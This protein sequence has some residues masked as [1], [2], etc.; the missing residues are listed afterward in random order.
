MA[1]TPAAGPGGAYRAVIV[2]TGFSGLCMAIGLKRSGVHDFVILEKAGEVGGTWRENTY[3]GCACDIMSL[4]YSFSFEPKSDWSRMFP[5]QHELLDYIKGVVDKYDL[6]QHIRF[7][8]EVTGA[9]YDD[10]S[11]TWRVT[12]QGEGAAPGEVVRGQA[13]MAGMGPLHQPNVPDLPGLASFEGE[14]FHSAEWNHDYD[15]AGKHVAVIGTGASAIQFVPRIAREVG[16]LTLF[17]RTPPWILPKPDRPVL[18][19][20]R[21]LFK[22]VPGVQR[23]YRSAI[24]LV[25]E[26]FVLGFENPRLLKLASGLAQWH[27]K[28]QVP[29]AELRAKLTPRYT[30]GCKRTLVSSDYYPALTRDN[31]QV[32]TAGVAEVRPRS[33]VAGDGTEHPVDAIIFGTGFHVTDAFEHARIVGRNGLRIQDAWKDGIEAHLG[34]TVAGFPNLF[35]LLGP[36]SGLGHN[37]MIFMIE[38]QV[39]YVLRCLELLRAGGGSRIAVRAG[40]QDRF[41]RWVRRRSEGAVWVSGGCTSW[42]LDGNGVNRA[43]WPASTV[44]YWLRTRR[45]DPADFEVARLP[46]ATG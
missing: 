7:R 23:G 6:A 35:L 21:A 42:Y 2:G 17:Q 32:T 18:G 24:Y 22:R 39:R 1:V 29:D 14:T 45:L 33:I 27:L 16:A 38:A 15:L 30:M 31:V 13:L 41:N 34:V 46:A 9:E 36:N 43:A 40:A 37:S 20:E 44:N 12:V 11:D 26:S 4:L 28:R 19:V 5:E 3:P 10:A 8:T 25:Q